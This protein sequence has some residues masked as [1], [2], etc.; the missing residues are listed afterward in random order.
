MQVEIQGSATWPGHSAHIPDPTYGQFRAG[1][2]QSLA[3]ESPGLWP[4]GGATSVPA[5]SGRQHKRCPGGPQGQRQWVSPGAEAWRV[6][7]GE[8]APNTNPPH[9]PSSPGPCGRGGG[10]PP[11]PLGCSPGLA[12]RPQRDPVQIDLA[13]PPSG[14]HA[15]GDV[16]EVRATS[17]LL[18]PVMN[19]CS[20]KKLGRGDHTNTLVKGP[21]R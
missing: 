19:L 1:Q 14:H 17:E 11:L 2:A 8:T 12:L 7:Y 21:S 16:S 18:L 3:R 4:G 9:D 13:S 6:M 5:D 15:H 10:C 20:P